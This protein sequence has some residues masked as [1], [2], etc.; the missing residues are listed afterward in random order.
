MA[1]SK[2]HRME[3]RTLYVSEGLPPQEIA[4][5]TGIPVST[6]CRWRQL[7]KRDGDDW[8]RA[9]FQVCLSSEHIEG[10]NRQ[11]LGR[12]LDMLT[13]TVES[14][15]AADM[16]PMECTKAL[17]SLADSY[18]KMTGAI[19]R[20]NPEVA[21]ADVAVQVLAIVHEVLSQRAPD[22]QDRLA[23]CLDEITAK[24]QE[25]FAT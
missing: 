3:V 18:N 9:R 25:R 15:H 4:R 20:T 6:I 5:K 13:A 12:Y 16:D 7:A 17:S 22:L 2:Q 24:I 1:W 21:V 23:D 19:K 11:I 8:D 14:I 10:L